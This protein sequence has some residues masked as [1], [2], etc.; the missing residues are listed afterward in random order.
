MAKKP[1]YKELEQRIR[2]LEK[3]VVKHELAEEKMLKGN[4]SYRDLMEAFPVGISISSPEGNVIDINSTGL[5]MFGYDSKEDFIKIPPSGH[6]YDEKDREC[7]IELHKNGLAKDF[8]S[9]F[10]RKDG[11]VFWGSLTSLSLTTATGAIQYINVFQ[12]ISE[13]KQ[14]NER[15]DHLNLV[16]RSIRNVSQLITKEK[17][18]ERLLQGACDNLIANRGYY[19]T[20]IVLVDESGAFLS[21]YEAGLGKAFLP[22]LEMLKRGEVSACARNALAQANVI[23]TENPHFECDDC[24]LSGMYNGRGGMTVRLEHEG[25][26]YGLLSASIP[27]EFTRD[28]EETKLFKEIA[29]DIAFALFGIEMEEDRMRSEEELRKRTRDLGKRV[30]ELNCLYDVSKLIETPDISLNEIIQGMVDLIP[31]SWRYPEITCSRIILEDEEY[32][33]VNFKETGWKQSSEIF[34]TGKRMGTLE[35][36]YLEERPEIYEGPFLKEERHLIDEI[37]DRLGMIIEHKQAEEILHREKLLGDSIVDNTPAGIAFLD[38][39]FVL[40]RCN[41]TY[42][43]FLRTYTP[44]TG[45]QALGMSYFDYAASSRPQVEEWFQKVRDTGQVDTRYGFKLVLKQGGQEKTSYW[46]TSVA[47]V[48]DI[49]GKAKG[50]LIL[51]QDVTER[52]QAEETLRIERDNF[53]NIL[54]SM[55]DGVYCYV[56]E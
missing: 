19:N 25:K 46:D 15:V 44:Y 12:D 38:N 8:E 30:K 16:L 43:E 39:D 28:K 45:K 49:D 52:T 23:V 9:R 6:Y 36:F 4:K 2:E 32:K 42:A 3:D 5:K 54:E 11:T 22:M 7:F 55:K 27:E 18:R 35:V 48:L 47:P 34:V 53:V 1:T 13:R 17:D 33:T 24:P 31:P 10:I 56:P 40:R 14:A 21:A 37:T 41:R 51:T 50:I 29:D 20:W 26:T